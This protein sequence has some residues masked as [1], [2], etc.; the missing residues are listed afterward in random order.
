MSSF[1]VFILTHG[2]SDRVF[3]YKNL[4][5]HGYSGQIYLL[6]DS[7]DKELPLYKE[8]YGDSV[9][10]FDKSDYDG[11][12][13]KMDN[14]GR[15]NVVVYARNAV[16]Q[17]ALNL[18]LDYIAVLDD[19]YLY[20]EFKVNSN[21]KY[22]CKYI[23]NLDAVFNV[24][25]EYL[26]KGNISALC[27][28][29]NGDFI[30]GRHNT[31]MAIKKE[32]RRKMMNLFFFDVRKPICFMGTINEDLTASVVEAIGGKVCLTT[33]LLALQQKITQ[34]N[35]GGLTDVYLSLG[36]YV[37]SFY[38]VMAAPSAVKIST[39]GNKDKRL[40]HEVT[41]KYCAPKILRENVKYQDKN[42]GGGVKSLEA[43]SSR[44]PP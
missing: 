33:P 2:R 32:P 38:S 7:E 37:K 9:V 5:K 6:C 41:W 36:T 29:Q 11:K 44:P 3:T 24:C 22:E 12:F 8:M 10:V 20:F 26:K 28:A 42:T 1:A 30:G 15:R 25:L 35:T 4:R 23:N 27:F 14:F 39:M 31:S 16:Y 34:S 40:H 17:A 13:D 21:Y 18:G 19:D 43:P